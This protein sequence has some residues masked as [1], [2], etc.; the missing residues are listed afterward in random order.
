MGQIVVQA[1]KINE[2]K[3]L[4][5]TGQLLHSALLDHTCSIVGLNVVKHYEIGEIV[6]HV[7]AENVA[8]LELG[9][10]GTLPLPC[11]VAICLA[12]GYKK[13]LR[14]MP[15]YT[16]TFALTVGKINSYII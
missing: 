5:V 10:S 2:S 9:N 1:V 15:I 11:P 3:D 6:W 8:G 4:L 7:S 12:N 13:Q 14:V 16:F